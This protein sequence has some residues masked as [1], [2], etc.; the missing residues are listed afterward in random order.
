MDGAPC[1]RVPL[2]R[3]SLGEDRCKDHD[4]SSTFAAGSHGRCVQCSETG[5]YCVRP[6]NVGDCAPGTRPRWKYITRQRGGGMFL[7]WRATPWPL[8]SGKHG[9]LCR[10]P[11]RS[12]SK[13]SV[14]IRWQCASPLALLS[15]VLQCVCEQHPIRL[16]SVLATGRSPGSL[17]YLLPGP[18]GENQRTK[19]TPTARAAPFA[20]DRPGSRPRERSKNR[21]GIFPCGFPCIAPRPCQ[22]ARPPAHFD[23]IQETSKSA[24]AVRQEEERGGGPGEQHH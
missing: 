15:L 12:A 16:A 13:S 23:A 8:V 1:R 10:L 20:R 24:N 19:T 22:S 6:R 21:W 14:A 5:V 11:L 4:G 18:G 7:L 17:T 9:P 2:R 3:L